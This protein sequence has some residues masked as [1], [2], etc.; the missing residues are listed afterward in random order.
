LHRHFRLQPL[1][2]CG[3]HR[4]GNNDPARCWSGQAEYGRGV[5]LSRL[6]PGFVSDE[7]Q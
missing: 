7:S 3:E 4:D 2:A 6:L 1:T 5:Y